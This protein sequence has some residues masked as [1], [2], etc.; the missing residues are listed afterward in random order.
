MERYSPCERHEWRHSARIEVAE[1]LRSRYGV[2]DAPCCSADT[3]RC[4]ENRPLSWDQR[5]V[6]IDLVRTTGGDSV[7]LLSSPMQS[8]PKPGWVILLTGG[9]SEEGYTWTLYGIPPR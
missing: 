4:T 8:P 2:G 5:F 7:R 6:G 9:N 1:L 3:S